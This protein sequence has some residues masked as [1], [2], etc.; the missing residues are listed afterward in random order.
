MMPTDFPSVDFY[1]DYVE[2]CER[3]MEYEVMHTEEITK[4]GMRVFRPDKIKVDMFGATEI[5]MPEKHYAECTDGIDVDDVCWCKGDE[6]GLHYSWAR[7][8]ETAQHTTHPMFTIKNDIAW[9]LD[10]EPNC[11]WCHPEEYYWDPETD[12]KVTRER[13]EQ[14]FWEEFNKDKEYFVEL[15]FTEF[16][17]PVPPYEP[18]KNGPHP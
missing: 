2:E 7:G 3:S 8:G 16:G 11:A 4:N 6:Y 5:T 18:H 17:L 13:A 1:L 12:K 15:Y 10:N 14:L 9:H